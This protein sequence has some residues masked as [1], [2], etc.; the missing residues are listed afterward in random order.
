[1]PKV[2][3]LRGLLFS[4]LLLVMIGV[5]AQPWCPPGAKWSHSYYLV[6]WISGE[7]YQGTELHWY[8]GDTTLGGYAAQ[9][10]EQHLYYEV[11]GTGE[12][13]DH[14]AGAAYTRYEGGVVYRWDPSMEDF[15]TL[16]WFGS[17][18]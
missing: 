9:R 1:M 18:R 6:D 4:M 17:V 16:L 13:G 7:T 2:M 14:D 11:L 15:D 5:R 3:R 12:Q 10:I 8:A